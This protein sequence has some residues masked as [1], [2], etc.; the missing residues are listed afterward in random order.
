MDHEAP[1]MTVLVDGKPEA[2]EIVIQ[3][4]RPKPATR[5]GEVLMESFGGQF[6]IG[7]V[8]SE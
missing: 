6:F 2:R 1:T 3:D 5:P 4:G 7:R 8:R